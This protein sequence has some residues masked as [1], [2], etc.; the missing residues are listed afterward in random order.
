MRPRNHI[1]AAGTLIL[2]FI[3]IPTLC[4]AQSKVPRT[5][6]KQI[7]EQMIRSREI[8]RDCAQEAGGY[9]ELV[10]VDYENY[11]DDRVPELVVVQ[12]AGC[13]SPGSLP[14]IWI[15]RKTSTGYRKIYGPISGDALKQNTKTNGYYDL[16]A[17]ERAGRDNYEGTMYRFDGIRYRRNYRPGI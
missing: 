7:V 14:F 2:V 6:H 15:Y 11:N 9:D 16:K 10:F 13:I 3:F 12:K 4:T 8:Q 17:V 5:V 1:I